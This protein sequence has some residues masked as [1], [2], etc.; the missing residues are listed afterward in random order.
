MNEYESLLHHRAAPLLGSTEKIEAV[1]RIR[2]GKF[3]VRSYIAGV[4]NRRIVIVEVVSGWLGV[5]PLFKEIRDIPFSSIA[6][7]STTGF[8]NSK[9]VRIELCS[10][11]VLLFEL[12]TMFRTVPDQRRFI[13]TMKELYSNCE[14][15]SESQ[16]S[17]FTETESRMSPLIGETFE[18]KGLNQN[19]GVGILAGGMAVVLSAA[20]CTAIT[21]ITEYQLGYL[22]IGVGL[23][24]GAA[25]R[26]FGRGADRIFGIAAVVLSLTG[27]VLGN[28]L[29]ASN[30]FS[31]YVDTAWL[32]TIE[33]LILSPKWLIRL[34]VN[35]FDITDIIFYVMAAFTSDGVAF[36]RKGTKED[37]KPSVYS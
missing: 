19:L 4:T 8:L 13:R 6:R 14:P 15:E 29:I 11:E 37:H 30:L 25:V 1:S 35:T 5:K 23:L 10:G 32:E 27:G 26:F 7:L 22:G 9:L 28:F 17:I 20:I 18:Q 12:N 24:V 34:L 36:D 16:Q 21:L 31:G 3:V 33:F 2:K